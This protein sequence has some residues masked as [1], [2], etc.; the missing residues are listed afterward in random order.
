MSESSGKKPT[1]ACPGAAAWLWDEGTDK[2]RISVKLVGHDYVS[3][4]RNYNA[5]KEQ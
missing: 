2:E 3:L 4:W 5:K 1:W